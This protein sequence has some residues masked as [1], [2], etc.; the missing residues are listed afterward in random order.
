M[1]FN[2]LYHRHQI[3]LFMSEHA[4][5]AKAREAHRGLATGYA[6]R[7]AAAKR[8]RRKVLPA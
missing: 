2:Y 4:D 3:A 5:G 8:D 1:D 7:I 6:A